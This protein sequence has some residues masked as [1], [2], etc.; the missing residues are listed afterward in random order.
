MNLVSVAWNVAAAFNP[1]LTIFDL[2]V[3]RTDRIVERFERMGTAARSLGSSVAGLGR[4]LGQ[5]ASSAVGAPQVNVNMNQ[6][7]GGQ[8]DE[9]ANAVADAVS[10]NGGSA[11]RLDVRTA[12]LRGMA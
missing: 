11:D 2:F 10:R 4:S 7:G 3:G 5:A 1:V 8:V 6:L 12:L 9:I